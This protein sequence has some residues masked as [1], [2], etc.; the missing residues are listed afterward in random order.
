MHPTP[1]RIVLLAVLYALATYAIAGERRWPVLRHYDQA[2]T[3]RIALP[4]GGIGTGTISLGGRGELR[5]WEIV[6]RPAHGYSPGPGFFAI[7]IAGRGVQRAT[8]L[9]QGPV[10]PADYE[11]AFGAR[12]SVLPG[13]PRFSSCAFDAAYPL[14]QVTL[15]DP[16]LPVSVRLMAFNPLVPP[17]A[18]K[19]G[20]PAAVFRYAVKNLSGD[21]L[22]V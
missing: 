11:G 9:L 10:D 5:D 22:D 2:H 15:A 16:R 8:R 1:C 13:L 12:P 4:L 7:H 19:S 20:I 17:D 21:P 6:N 3:T 14:G 18:E